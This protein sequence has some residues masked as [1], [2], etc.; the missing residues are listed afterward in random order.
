MLKFVLCLFGLGSHLPVLQGSKILVVF[1]E[2]ALHAVIS[3]Y[4]LTIDLFIC[5][6]PFLRLINISERISISGAGAVQAIRL[7]CTSQ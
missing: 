2:R 4:T 6:L 7:V 1:K 3:P 5:I